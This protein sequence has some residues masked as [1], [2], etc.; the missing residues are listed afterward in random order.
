MEERVHVKDDFSVGEDM[1]TYADWE[2]CI[3]KILYY[4]ERHDERRRIAEKAHHRV[5]REHTYTHR[6]L[7]LI[8]EIQEL[9][10]EVTCEKGH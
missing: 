8:A 1:V 7:R 9:R 6:A 4:R 10:N 3:G 2:D 5:M